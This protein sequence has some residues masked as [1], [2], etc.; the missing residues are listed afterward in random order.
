M[1]IRSWVRTWWASLATD[2]RKHWAAGALIAMVATPVVAFAFTRLLALPAIPSAAIGFMV[3]A[4]AARGVGIAKESYDAKHPETHTADVDDMRWTG[5]G[6][7]IGAAV[8]VVV[9]LI[10]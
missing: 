5:R 6:G 10:V 1:D 3:G 8:G 4:L 9:F 7:V 2:K